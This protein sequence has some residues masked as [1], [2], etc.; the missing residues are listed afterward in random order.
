MIDWYSQSVEELAET[1]QRLGE[2]SYRSKQLFRWLHQRGAQS[3]DG[4][5][6]LGKR[7]DSASKSWRRLRRCRWS[8]GKQRRTA[9]L[10]F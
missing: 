3:F 6:D 10:S 4:M 2:P 5:S 8:S 1:L 9:R 7:Y